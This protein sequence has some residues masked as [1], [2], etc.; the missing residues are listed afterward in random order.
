MKLLKAKKLVAKFEPL[1]VDLGEEDSFFY[2][3]WEFENGLIWVEEEVTND[4]FFPS[5]DAIECN[6]NACFIGVEETDEVQDIK[7]IDLTTIFGNSIGE[8]GIDAYQDGCI[9]LIRELAH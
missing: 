6:V 5:R 7:A 1:N 9:E 2:E 8:F 3:V 4:S